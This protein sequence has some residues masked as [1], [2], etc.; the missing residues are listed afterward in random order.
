MK[1]DSSQYTDRSP[2]PEV[3]KET[4]FFSLV[5][6]YQDKLFRYSYFRTNNREVATDIVQDIFM[7]V[8]KYMA[9]GKSIEHEEAFLYRIAKNSVID[10]F[11]KRKS[12]SLDF[13]EEK[14]FDMAATDDT[15]RTAEKNADLEHL[16]DLIDTLDE[17]QKQLLL[18][19]YGEEKSLDEIAMIYQKTPN[20]IAV[21]IHRIISKL[22]ERHH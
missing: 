10:F 19:R 12:L 3:D 13:L 18:L 16:T 9:A 11:K 6:Q 5:Q 2:K 14:G 22:Q 4:Y 7:K 20:A 15:M 21:R 17:D 1:A 8:W